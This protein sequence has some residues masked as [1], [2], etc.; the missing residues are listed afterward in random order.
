[1]RRTTSLMW[2]TGRVT[3]EAIRADSSAAS[4]TAKPVAASAHH[5]SCWLL[6]CSDVKS[7]SSATKPSTTGSA[8]PDSSKPAA[9]ESSTATKS[10]RTSWITHR[11]SPLRCTRLPVK[12]GNSAPKRPAPA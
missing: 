4:T 11:R 9:S 1:M 3:L 10:D 5:S 7:Y 2:A 12:S 6:R 8:A